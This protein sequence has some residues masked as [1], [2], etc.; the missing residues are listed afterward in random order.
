MN[1]VCVFGESF[2]DSLLRS[3]HNII[4]CE[5][6]PNEKSTAINKIKYNNNTKF[7]VDSIM[8]MKFGNEEETK[9]NFSIELMFLNQVL[10]FKDSHSVWDTIEK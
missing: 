2:T 9:T 10:V 8:M 1:G 3:I 5:T 6:S 4:V 7:K